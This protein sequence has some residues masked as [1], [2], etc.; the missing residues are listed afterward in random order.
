MITEDILMIYINL[1]VDILIDKIQ[2][3]EM[4]PEDLKKGII[5]KIPKKEDTQKR[6]LEGNYTAKCK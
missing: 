5:I 4:L 2:S 6:K 3:Q 1:T